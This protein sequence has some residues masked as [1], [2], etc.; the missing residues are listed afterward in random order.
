MSMRPTPSSHGYLQFELKVPKQPDKARKKVC[1]AGVAR[2]IA[3]IDTD[4]FGEL[5]DKRE[6]VDRRV[7]DSLVRVI[8]EEGGEQD[9]KTKYLGIMPA[10]S[11]RRGWTVRP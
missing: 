10:R 5:C 1:Q 4:L 8:D 3:G 2:V 7:V 6:L 9:R 11:R